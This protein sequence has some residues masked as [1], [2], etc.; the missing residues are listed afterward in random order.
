MQS[1]AVVTAAYQ[2]IGPRLQRAQPC[3]LQQRI[4]LMHT[5]STAVANA[6][7]SPPSEKNLYYYCKITIIERRQ[8]FHF[9]SFYSPIRLLSLTFHF[10]VENKNKN[11]ALLQVKTLARRQHTL[12]HSDLSVR[13][14]WEQIY[15][16]SY[17]NQIFKK[18]LCHREF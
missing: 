1:F 17:A 11:S 14:N 4:L 10:P 9:Q 8:C 15:L 6:V 3:I 16:C 2:V 18:Y 13:L 7:L 5:P 12:K